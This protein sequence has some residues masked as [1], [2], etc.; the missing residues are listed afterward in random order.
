M[1]FGPGS[2]D[3]VGLLGLLDGAGPPIDMRIAARLSWGCWETAWTEGDHMANPEQLAILKK[4][5]KA[6]SNWRKQNSEVLPRLT[7]AGLSRANLFRADL[8]RANLFR[9]D[10]S[11]AD[12][13]G[14]D[15]SGAD[16]SRADLTG[17]DLSEA[18]LTD[19]N[20][21]GSRLVKCNLTGATLTGATLYGTARDDWI[22]KDVE[23]RYVCWDYGGKIR[24]PK[25][26]DL[27]P[28]E[29]ER[30]YRALPTVEYVF[31]EGMTPLDPLILDRVVQAIRE[32][33]P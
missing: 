4:G 20:L 21:E 6:W 22:I 30:L 14:A 23:C 13:S 16:L 8:S 19:A 5:A 10:L 32:Q 9:A 29:F 2:R 17:A 28:G 33:N 26:R 7:G 25:D 12:L 18:N 1:P 24:S 3:T 11:R 15:L 31:Q 27:A